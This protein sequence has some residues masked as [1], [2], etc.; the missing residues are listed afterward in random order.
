[1]LGLNWSDP[2]V[3]G[4]LAVVSGV[5]ALVGV[6][7]T[8]LARR[9]LR[10]AAVVAGF[11]GVAGL[12]TATGLSIRGLTA[13]RQPAAPPAPAELRAPALT[14]QESLERFRQAD[15]AG[16]LALVSRLPEGEQGWYAVS[17]GDLTQTIVERGTVEPVLATD[18]KCEARARGPGPVAG[19][20]KSV[21]GEGTAVKKGQLLLELDDAPLR[22]Q[23]KAQ[24]AVVGQKQAALTRAEKERAGA[25][26]VEAARDALAAA[27]KRVKELEEDIA[28]CKIVAPH[29]GLLVYYVPEQARFGAGDAGVVA[30]GEPVREGQ[31]LLRVC[32]LS[33]LQVQARVHEALVSRVR[34]NQAARV[35]VDA[36]PGRRLSGRVTQVSP[37]ASQQDWLAADVKVYPT[38]VALEGD[39]TGLKP[40]MSAEVRLTVEQRRGVLRLPVPAVLG[41]GDKRVCYVREGNGIAERVVT[42]GTSDGEF[43]EVTGGLKEGEQVLRDPR[44]LAARL[45]A[46]PGPQARG[47]SGRQAARD[48]VV[49]SVRP[50]PVDSK[51]RRSRAL[52]YGLTY[53]DLGR[54]AA[55][56]GVERVVPVRS[57]PQ[58]LRRRERR[59]LGRVV[60]TTPDHADAAGLALAAGRFFTAAEDE[61]QA[62]V[63]VLGAAAAERLFPHEGPLGEVVV[64]GRSSFVV[65][66]VLRDRG[67]AEGD[68]DAPAGGDVYVPLRTCRGRIG[69]TVVIRRRGTLEREQVELTQVTLTLARAEQVAPTVEAARAALQAFHAKKDWD[70]L[71]G[72]AE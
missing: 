60:A 12:A 65:V 7:C 44:A 32:D 53:A 37:V 5:L 22:E 48:V 57:F 67:A 52:A 27:T 10:V 23:L 34:V 28:H 1:M 49:Q 45:A 29:D 31:K 18:L 15:A 41:P 33:K 35:R 62:N 16:R 6:T 3:I 11:L 59:H 72:V 70:V 43:V 20:I 66:G 26:A 50:A 61:G 24:Q 13:L 69:Q 42:L 4:T 14:A 64:V 68:P 54:L 2:W 17:R 40:G 8:S 36:F 21:L 39:V 46:L 30:Q 47:P 55:L 63:A 25:A 58:E 71:P 51:G 38:T 19:V 9:R 56:P